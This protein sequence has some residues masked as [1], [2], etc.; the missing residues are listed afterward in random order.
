VDQAALYTKLDAVMC[1]APKGALGV[2]VSGGGDSVA[3]LR[4]LVQWAQQNGCAL[5]AATVNHHLRDAA[6]TEAAFVSALCDDLGVHHETLHW[7]DWSG[8]GNL[9]N[10]ARDARKTLLSAWALQHDLSAVALG[11]TQDD[12]AET[13]LMRLA[14]GSGVDGL[15]GIQSFHGNA[16]IFVRPLLEVRRYELRAY[17]KDLGQDWMNDPSNDDESF[18]RIKMRNAFPDL[19]KLGLTVERLAQTAQG[20]QTSRA[21]LEQMTQNAA[22]Q[23]C[24]P[25]QY[26]AVEIDL[27]KLKLEPL[28]VQYRVFTHAMAWVSGATYRPRFA[29]LKSAYGNIC[30]GQGQTLGG[31]FI[32]SVETER[33]I[34]MRELAHMPH[35]TPTDALYDGRWRIVADFKNGMTVGP[36][37]EKGLP[38]IENWREMGV[39]RDIL[40][41]TPALWLHETVIAAPLLGSYENAEISLKT[42]LKHFYKD[43]VSH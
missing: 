2:A 27:T 4:L 40:L 31:C 13:F 17:L 19:E 30:A 32:K 7:Q 42:D 16:P 29:A 28:D 5:Y 21:A 35:I 34:V 36:L 20:L 33:F 39:V 37:G 23:C 9:Q 25:N 10:A 24:V 22:R 3:L 26:G 38:Q 6:A 14:R 15:S 11:H 43:I 18:D 41:Q 12:Q 8:K 1:K